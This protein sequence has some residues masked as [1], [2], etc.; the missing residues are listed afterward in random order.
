MIPTHDE[1]KIPSG[2]A[3]I[4][5]N[6]DVDQLEAV[7]QLERDDVILAAASAAYFGDNF[8]LGS[9]L[10]RSVGFCQPNEN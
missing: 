6:I 3:S 8:I 4:Q 2:F 9:Y 10:D 7:K 1:L 5:N